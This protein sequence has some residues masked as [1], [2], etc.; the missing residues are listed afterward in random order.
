MVRRSMQPS[1]RRWLASAIAAL[2]LLL[3]GC[4]QDLL[5]AST[6]HR[7]SD[8]EINVYPASY[9]P[10]ILGAMHAYLNNPAGLRDA[11][12]S[13]PALKPVSGATRYVVCVRF[14]AKTK[15]G[16]YAGVKEIAAI[17]IAGRFDRFVDT[18]RETC[19]E[20]TYKPFPELQKL[21]N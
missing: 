12:I 19:A 17:F 15:S 18:P 3:G 2:A 13:E 6:P 9:N 5:P 11:G 10:E 21:S 1:A 7:A 4:A 16:T 14:N 20:T 8:E